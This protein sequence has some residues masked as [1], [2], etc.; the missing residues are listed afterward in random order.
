MNSHELSSDLALDPPAQLP[1]PVAGR[2]GVRYNSIREFEMSDEKDAMC[3]VP[4]LGLYE[5]DGSSRPFNPEK[6]EYTWEVPWLRHGEGERRGW[7]L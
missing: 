2:R 3:T 7:R 5:I 4:G 1:L 6:L